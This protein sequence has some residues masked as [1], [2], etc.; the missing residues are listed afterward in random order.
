MSALYILEETA[1]TEHHARAR[2][3]AEVLC[4]RVSDMLADGYAPGA[5]HQAMKD[6]YDHHSVRGR[7]V[8]RDAM[9]EVLDWFED[10]AL[11][12]AG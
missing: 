2:E 6:L 4:R 11:D 8:E 9:A 12:Q 3:M 10:E 1:R 5:V 7:S